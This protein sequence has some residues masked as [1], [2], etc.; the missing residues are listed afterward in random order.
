M[1]LPCSRTKPHRLSDPLRRTR[2]SRRTRCGLELLV[3]PW[4]RDRTCRSTAMATSTSAFAS[5]I[6]SIRAR[7][8]VFQKV[9]FFSHFS[10]VFVNVCSLYFGSFFPAPISYFPAS[11]SQQVPVSDSPPPWLTGPW[12]RQ[13]I[14]VGKAATH[15]SLCSGCRASLPSFAYPACPVHLPVLVGL[16]PDDSMVHLSCV[17]VLFLCKPLRFPLCLFVCWTKLILIG[18][19]QCLQSQSGY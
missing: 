4:W 14:R 15:F 6:R 18:S 12:Q 2:I 1:S 9:F 11:P 3:S 16:P 10:A 5:A 8:D 13:L 7:L 17:V 19:C